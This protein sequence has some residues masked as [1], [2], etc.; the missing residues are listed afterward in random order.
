M[1]RLSLLAVVVALLGF[2]S[3]AV[4][5]SADPVAEAAWTGT[6]HDD[7]CVYQYETLVTIVCEVTGTSRV[8]ASSAGPRTC[9]AHLSGWVAYSAR[10]EWIC[11][12]NGC[13]TPD[14]YSMS[15][16]GVVKGAATVTLT[17]EHGV[18]QRPVPVRFVGHGTSYGYHGSVA[19]RPGL[20]IAAGTLHLDCS[21]STQVWTGATLVA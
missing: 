19:D 4:S 9:V 1:R 13:G 18:T 16:C 6:W 14:P 21:G 15:T 17:D 11:V 12:P 2:G 3:P 5:A 20:R 8:C 7:N 10:I